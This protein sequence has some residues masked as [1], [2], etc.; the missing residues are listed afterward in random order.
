MTA[1]PQFTPM[2]DYAAIKLKQNAA[3]SSGDY[4]K[5]G[6]TLQIAGESLAEAMDLSPDSKSHTAGET[7]KIRRRPRK[8]R[9]QSLR[10][11]R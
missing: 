1:M 4:A 3:W 8:R 9:W 2:P 6:T 7:C 11:R 10:R 5:I